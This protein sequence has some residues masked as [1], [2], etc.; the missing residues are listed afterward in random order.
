MLAAF[1]SIVH[2]GRAK[3]AAPQ[4][5][6]GRKAPG[7][8]TYAAKALH[9]HYWLIHDDLVRTLK[10]AEEKMDDEFIGRS[11]FDGIGRVA[12]SERSGSAKTRLPLGHG[13]GWPLRPPSLILAVS[14]WSV[15]RPLVGD[16]G[17]PGQCLRSYQNEDRSMPV[18]RAS[19]PQL[20]FELISNVTLLA[21]GE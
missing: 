2:L 13:K 16:P 6:V 12:K 5:K 14:L 19:I 4:W 18:T 7:V 21:L 20:V 3:A 15:I 1:C 17:P 10:K 9:H 11:T 8:A